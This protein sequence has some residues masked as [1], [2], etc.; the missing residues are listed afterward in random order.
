MSEERESC[1]NAAPECNGALSGEPCRND[2]TSAKMEAC[3]NLSA[4]TA[5]SE[6]FGYMLACAFAFCGF[7]AGLFFMHIVASFHT[8]ESLILKLLLGLLPFQITAPLMALTVLKQMAMWKGW[9]GALEWDVPHLETLQRY[10]IHAA[11]FVSAIFCAVLLNLLSKA[12][13]D[14]LGIPFEEQSL[15][16]MTHGN[17]NVFFWAIAF[18][19]VMILAPCTEEMIYRLVLYKTLNGVLHRH[20]LAASLT[21][22][23]FALAHGVMPMVPALFALGMLFQEAKRRGGLKQSILL[24]SCYNGLMLVL[25]LLFGE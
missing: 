14:R 8:P 2:L 11:L 22:L 10:R 7:G 21:A 5:R 6:T 24:H 23:C 1:E 19:S 25:V 17:T 4:Q 20:W 12:I 13:C 16:Q 18:F 3:E 15:I 9:H